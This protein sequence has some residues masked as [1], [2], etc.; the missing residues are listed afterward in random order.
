METPADDLLSPLTREILSANPTAYRQLVVPGATPSEAHQLLDGVGPEK[1]FA[2]PIKVHAHAVAAL[3]GL[4]LWHDGLHQCHE[5]AQ[6]DPESVLKQTPA[7]TGPSDRQALQRE[8]AGIATTLDLWHAIMH[9]RE[10]DFS[11]SKYWYRRCESHQVIKRMG[12]VASSLAG[13]LAEDSAVAHAVGK[14]WSPSGFVDLVQAVRNK[15]NDPRHELAI[16]LQRAEWEA[17]FSHN[18]REAVA[19]DG[20]QLD[21][22]DQRVIHP[23]GT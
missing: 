15:P 20:S 13:S 12:A 19:A 6:M 3:A 8:L 10:G 21:D 1:L 7:G 9:R 5:I 11:N 17:L 22:W 18:V 2:V 14:G 16:R 4:W 23:S